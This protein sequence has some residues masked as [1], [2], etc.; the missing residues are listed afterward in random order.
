MKLDNS[1]AN[2]FA[3]CP[4]LFQEKYRFHTQKKTPGDARAFGKRIHDLL[5][6][7]FLELKGELWVPPILDPDDPVE[8]EAQEMI[9][10]YRA[11]YPVEDFDVVEVEQ[12]FEIPIPDS[13]H[14]YCGK[15]DGVVRGR[16]TGRLRLLEHKSEKRGQ[17]SNLPK[18]WAARSQVGLYLFSAQQFYGEPFE[19]I[20]L[21]VLTRR[22]P[23]GRILPEFRRDNL[24]R[25]QQQIEK[26]VENLRAIA[27]RIQEYDETYG[28]APWPEF[29]ENCCKGGFDCD[30]YGLHVQCEGKR[31]P[32]YMEKYYE[33][34]EDYLSL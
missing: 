12:Y 29:T 15:R 18:V 10:A 5:K 17:K 25:S 24:Q 13:P 26:A 9:E 2:T 16:N 34:T 19:D 21:D 20:I 14:T 23:A 22:S 33:P 32:E 11:F 30:F 3:F 27:N 4:R 31:I 7:H 1:A 8:L 28:L 6:A